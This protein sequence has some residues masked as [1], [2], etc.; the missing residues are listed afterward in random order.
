MPVEAAEVPEVLH[1]ENAVAL[2]PNVSVSDNFCKLLKALNGFLFIFGSKGL[3]LP[4]YCTKPQHSPR[5]YG[6][7]SSFHFRLCCV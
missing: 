5:Y 6:C 7:I 1:E 2:D 4:F 3:R